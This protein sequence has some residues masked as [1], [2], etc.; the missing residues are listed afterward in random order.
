M[1]WVVGGRLQR[2]GTTYTYSWFMLMYGRNQNNIVKQFSSVAQLCRT[3]CDPMDYSMPGIPVHYQLPEFTQIHLSQWCHPTI[4]SS[5]V[6][7]SSCL[8]SFPASGSSLRSQFFAP[9]G[10]NIG[11]SASA[12]V[13]PMNTQ[14]WFSLGWTDPKESPRR[15]LGSPCSP[16]DSQE[17]SPTPQLKSINSLVLTLFYGPTFTFIHDHW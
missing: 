1:G 13:L 6:L 7:F 8:L 16:R 4:S 12:S 14:D 3:L 10:Q 9:G 2:K 11:A 15:L 5:V 17:S